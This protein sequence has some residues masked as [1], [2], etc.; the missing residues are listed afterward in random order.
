MGIVDLRGAQ[1]M[2]GAD[3]MQ[4]SLFVVAKLDEFVPVDHPLRPILVIV[5]EALA[6]MDSS[7]GRMYQSTGRASIA[8]EKLLRAL[9]V[10]VLY[11]IRSE[12]MLVEQLRYNL[13]FRWFVGLAIEDQVWDHSSFT[14]NRERLVAAGAIDEL[15]DA[16]L[17]QA[18]AA[19]LLSSE[20][21]SVDGTLIRAW[22]SHKSFV[23]KDGS[24]DGGA[25]PGRNAEA[26]WHGQ[27]RSNDTH[28]STTDPDARLYRKSKSA[29]A[30]LAYQGHVLMEN[31][32]GLA[33]DACVSHADG[34]AERDS[35]V[36]M[37]AFIATATRKT[38]G[39]DKAY[40]TI[41]FVAAC[42]GLNVTPHVA[43]NNTY[44]ASCLDER[45]IGHQ[46]YSIS[47]RIRKRVEE[48]FGWAKTIG[49]IRQTVY[50]GL[51][52]VHMHFKLT[53]TASNLVRMRTLGLGAQP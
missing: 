52:R 10:Q 53:M 32:S 14:K 27:A 36:N 22:A 44:R 20:H 19:G 45:T 18:R 17:A 47:Q 8:P 11:S 2:R 7:L 24:G 1:A 48:H 3:S 15:F 12:R 5:N 4:E 41:G 46:G 6:R 33:V 35:A 28:A 49:Q 21:F 9:L 13:L 51:D 34:F 43:Q 40:D 50:R 29:E 25:G 42:R 37:L 30:M 16:I 23:P 26:S 39:A 38:L 31:R